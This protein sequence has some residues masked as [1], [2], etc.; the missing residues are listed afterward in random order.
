M[1]RCDAYKCPSAGACAP[2]W[3][4]SAAGKGS[5]RQVQIRAM[6]RTCIWGQKEPGENA[7]PATRSLSYFP[8]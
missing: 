7:G 3:T 2:V 4:V 5:R 1:L 6:L 8:F